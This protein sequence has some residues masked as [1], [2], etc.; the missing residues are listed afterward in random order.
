M[1]LTYTALFV[2]AFLCLFLSTLPATSALS[3]VKTQHLPTVDAINL[4]RRGDRSK[5]KVLQD[6]WQLYKSEGQS[7]DASTVRQFC[8]TSSRMRELFKELKPYT[9]GSA[10]RAESAINAYFTGKLTRGG[11]SS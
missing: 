7:L 5:D 4:G 9:E 1:K 8:K 6:I 3:V 11:S 10:T 2:L